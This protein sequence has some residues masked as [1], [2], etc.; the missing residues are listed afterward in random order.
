M[1]VLFFNIIILFLE[2]NDYLLKFEM[3]FY[4][5]YVILVIMVYLYFNLFYFL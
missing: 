1:I 2:K 5:L 4:V 3:L